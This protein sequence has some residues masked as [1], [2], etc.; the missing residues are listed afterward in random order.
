M[1]QRV[2]Y[3]IGTVIIAMV[4]LASPTIPVEAA[5]PILTD[6]VVTPLTLD[7]GNGVQKV[8]ISVQ[9]NDPDDDLNINKV[10][11]VTRLKDGTKTKT[12]LVDDGAGVDSVAGDGRFTG[13]VDID[14]DQ[15]QRV[16][17]AVKAK[18]VEKNKAQK[19]GAIV[20]IVNTGT[21]PLVNELQVTPGELARG[22][23]SQVVTISVMVQ[24]PD[25]DL[26][27]GEGNFGS[28]DK[29]IAK[30]GGNQTIDLADY[31]TADSDVPNIEWLINGLT[32]P[33]SILDLG[34]KLRLG[35]LA[36]RQPMMRTEC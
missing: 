21:A 9:V 29:F 15:A 25:G 24:D 3:L 13:Q 33:D 5:P 32:A 34:G 27:H 22:I 35:S 2:T 8:T 16:Y 4:W 7:R 14:T 11:V 28:F 17:L 30:I 20:S 31:L 1:G 12:F 6:L 36:I 26:N 10:Q 18:D 19:V 23:D